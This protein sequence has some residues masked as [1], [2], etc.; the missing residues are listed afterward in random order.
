MQGII[1]D[2]KKKKEKKEMIQEFQATKLAIRSRNENDLI[3]NLT[4]HFLDEKC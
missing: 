3:K 4:M 2:K 1:D